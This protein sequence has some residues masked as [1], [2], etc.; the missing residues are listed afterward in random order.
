MTALVQ[1]GPAGVLVLLLVSLLLP[2]AQAAQASVALDYKTEGL[3]LRAHTPAGTKVM[4]LEDSITFYADRV[5]VPRPAP[6]GQ[7]SWRKLGYRRRATWW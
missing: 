4:A 6:I 3:W 7:A 2:T 5:R 1:W